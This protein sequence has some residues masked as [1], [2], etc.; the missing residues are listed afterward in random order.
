MDFYRKVIFESEW[1][2][3]D[4]PQD[5]TYSGIIS[6]DTVSIIMNDSELNDLDVK[7][8]DIGNTYL[9]VERA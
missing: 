7:C 5:M 6:R 9:N 1:H 3:T 2:L 4:L 8:F